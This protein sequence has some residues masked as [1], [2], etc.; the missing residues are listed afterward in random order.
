MKV[1]SN[2]YEWACADSKD[3]LGAV[4]QEFIGA[5][6]HDLEEWEPLP[7]EKVLGFWCY[8]TGEICE[9]GEPGAAVVKKTCGEWAVQHGRG[10]LGSS[11]Q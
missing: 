1:W 9:I 6:E 8:P 11:E 5:P 7:D 4:L 10:Y 2:E 3:D